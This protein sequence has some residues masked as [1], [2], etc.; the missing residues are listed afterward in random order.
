MRVSLQAVLTAQASLR[1]NEAHQYVDSQVDHRIHAQ[2]FDHKCLH[3]VTLCF[4]LQ[5]GSPGTHANS[6]SAV[7]SANVYPPGPVAG[8]HGG[9]SSVGGFNHDPHGPLADE[10]IS[11]NSSSHSV[12]ASRAALAGSSFADS[13]ASAERHNGLDVHSS[14]HD[15]N[16]LGPS[17]ATPAY[18]TE[19]GNFK[20]GI[21]VSST[22]ILGGEGTCTVQP[23]SHDS[24]LTQQQQHIPA[25]VVPK[26]NQGQYTP[27]TA[28]SQ[29]SQG[30]TPAAAPSVASQGQYM[31]THGHQGGRTAPAVAPSDIA[32]RQAPVSGLA[33]GSQNQEQY[34]PALAASGMSHAGAVPAAAASYSSYDSSESPHGSRQMDD[35]SGIGIGRSPAANDALQR[36]R[37]EAANSSLQHER[38]LRSFYSSGVPYCLLDKHILKAKCNPAMSMLSKMCATHYVLIECTSR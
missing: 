26:Q 14:A 10:T 2:L 34:T 28:V 35:S 36:G 31:A 8:T 4:L 38:S 22:P 17:G 16:S 15:Y 19:T 20:R 11:L 24:P 3:A 21:Q 37:A 33:N 12:G 27:A 30:H 5:A 23:L 25:A 29:F 7:A 32:Q 9:S 18:E 1:G 13:E 6:N